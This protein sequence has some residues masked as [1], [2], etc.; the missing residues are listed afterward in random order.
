M[1]TML[2]ATA[3][4]AMGPILYAPAKEDGAGGAKT[5]DPKPPAAA[6]AE[7][8]KT[9]EAER[10]AAA[11]NIIEDANRTISGAGRPALTEVE[12]PPPAAHTDIAAANAEIDDL[13]AAL[14]SAQV[15]AERDGATLR[16]QLN[17][18]TEAHETLK[19]RMVSGDLSTTQRDLAE[20]A[21]GA[22][23]APADLVEVRVKTPLQVVPT[24]PAGYNAARDG[25]LP[26][27]FSLVRGLNMVPRWVAD[28]WLVKGSLEDA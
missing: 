5:T 26:G 9:A 16:A 15:G 18:V 22:D 7:S 1:K 27:A 11:P 20:D 17:I 2:F 8:A 10:A 3:L 28:H 4:A 23:D 13:R 6:S 25:P 19:A 14:H 24:P 21:L 12:P